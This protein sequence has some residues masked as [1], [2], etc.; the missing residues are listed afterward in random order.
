MGLEQHRLDDCE[1]CEHNDR[2]ERYGKGGVCFRGWASRV[3]NGPGQAQ[4]ET[5]DRNT[6]AVVSCWMVAVSAFVSVQSA[7]EETSE[8][9]IAL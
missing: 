4:R 2:Q 1:Q 6:Q 8:R 9:V 3:R 7:G 5:S